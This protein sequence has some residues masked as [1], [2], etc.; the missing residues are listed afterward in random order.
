MIGWIQ[1]FTSV[2][3]KHTHEEKDRNEG[4][5]IMDEGR[6]KRREKRCDR[7]LKLSS[8]STLVFICHLLLDL[9]QH[10][11]KGRRG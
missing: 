7:V 4:G 5:M 11:Q 6:K 1:I 9:H 8:F 10:R 2:L 3:H